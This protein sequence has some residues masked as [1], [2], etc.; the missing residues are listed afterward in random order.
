MITAI[1]IALEPDRAMTG[2]AREANATLRES[3]PPVVSS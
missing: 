1:D 2:Q 3:F